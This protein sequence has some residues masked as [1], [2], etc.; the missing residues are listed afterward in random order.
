MASL[1][2]NALGAAHR[3]TSRILSGA[4]DA[5]GRPLKIWWPLS[6]SVSARSIGDAGTFAAPIIAI[7]GPS[8]RD[9]VAAAALAILPGTSLT[10][11]AELRLFPATNLPREGVYFMAGPTLDEAIFYC[12]SR[13]TSVA[14]IVEIE[15]TQQT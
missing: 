1:F 9:A 6:R 11:S 7:A 5:Q 4:N 10:F 14:G 2:A 13:A 3:A 15:A 8:K 12:C